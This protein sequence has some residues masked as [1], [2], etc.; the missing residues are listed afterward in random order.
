MQS[1]ML[2][3]YF[4]LVKIQIIKMTLQARKVCGT[5]EKQA[6]GEDPGFYDRE[7]ISRCESLWGGGEGMR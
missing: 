6:P 2:V 5:F 7:I 4:V 1:F 3:H